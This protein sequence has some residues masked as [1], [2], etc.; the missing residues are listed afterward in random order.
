MPLTATL[1]PTTPLK[2]LV[3]ALKDLVTE[4]NW[5]ADTY[6]DADAL[7]LRAMDA[8]HV[9]LCDVPL[10]TAGFEP[11]C[12]KRGYRKQFTKMI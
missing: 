5:H 1:P 8:S 9:A 4:G 10:D 12:S 3:D 2:T 7:T 11:I 6:T